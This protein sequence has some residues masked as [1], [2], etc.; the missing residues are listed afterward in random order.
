MVN[1]YHCQGTT[2]EV[3]PCSSLEVEIVEEIN[4]LGKGNQEYGFNV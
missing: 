3:L 1:G 2:S 4:W